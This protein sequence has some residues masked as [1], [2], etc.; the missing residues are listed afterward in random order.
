[1][2]SFS[3]TRRERSL[4]GSVKETIRSSPQRSNPQS[5]TTAAASGASPSPQRAG[6]I[7]QPTS[8]TGSPSTSSRLS[9]T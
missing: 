9:P 8:T 1:M 6:A 7:D 4:S 2:P 3:I 5:S